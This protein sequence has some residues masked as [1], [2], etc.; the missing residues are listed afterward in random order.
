MVLIDREEKSIFE[1]F[2][3]VQQALR[4]MLI[5]LRSEITSGTETTIRVITWLS[6]Q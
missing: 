5:F 3:A 6:L 2:V 4:D 1:T